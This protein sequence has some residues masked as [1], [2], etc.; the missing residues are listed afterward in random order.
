MF[1]EFFPERYNVDQ[2][3]LV[4]LSAVGLDGTEVDPSYLPTITGKNFGV[5]PPNFQGFSLKNLKTFRVWRRKQQ[6]VT[7]S[8]LATQPLTL[9]KDHVTAAELSAAVDLQNKSQQ[10]AQVQVAQQQLETMQAK[11]KEWDAIPADPKTPKGALRALFEAADKG[12]LHGVR[13]RMKSK[14]AGADQLLDVTAHLITA[15]QSARHLAVQRFGEANVESL[16]SVNS[17]G[18]G[19]PAMIDLEGFMMVQPWQPRSD[20]GLEVSNIAITKGDNGEFFV[21]MRETD[22]ASL[23]Q[24]AA[25]MTMAIGMAT[26]MD[27]LNQLMKDNPS[28]TFDQLRKAIVEP[29]TQPTT[30]NSTS[31]PVH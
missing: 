6:W 4:T 15:M 23:I 29:A 8:G 11:R 10:Q 20:G 30:Q 19:M 16:Q 31:Q 5:S 28:L 18:L 17:S 25:A 3:N 21:D 14:Q 24:K 1:V 26:R 2:G 27:Q 12:D 13:A 9:P 22:Q 7:F